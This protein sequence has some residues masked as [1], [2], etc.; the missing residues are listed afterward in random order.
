MKIPEPSIHSRLRRGEYLDRRTF[1]GNLEHFLRYLGASF[2]GLLLVLLL[3]GIPSLLVLTSTYGL[4]DAVRAHAEALLAGKFYRVNIGRV[5]FSPTR[6]FILEELKVHDLTPSQRLIV[7]ANKIA[8]SVN[9]ESLLKRQLALERIYLRDTTLDVPLG[10]TEEPR[11]RL[12]HVQGLII[13]PPSQFRVS[14]ATFEIAG[15]KVNVS[16]NFLNPRKFSPK[17]VSPEGPGKTA[18][19]IDAIQRELRSI[20]WSE[21]KPELTIQ[22]AG[23]LSDSESI[24][25]ESA[26]LRAGEG[27]WHG[28]SFRKIFI[29]LHYADRRLFLEQFLTDDGSGIFQAAGKADFRENNACVDFAGGFRGDVLPA[30]LLSDQKPSGWSAHEPVHLEGH[31]SADWMTGKPVLGGTAR[32]STGAFAYHGVK[33]DS[34]VAGVALQEGKLLIRDL[35]TSGEPGTIEADLMKAPSDNRLRLKA[36]LFPAKLAPLTG[37]KTREALEVMNF[38]DPLEINFEGGAPSFDPLQFHGEGTLN[39]GKAAM[40]DAWIDK[41]SSNFKVADGAITFRDILV[42]IGEGT[43]RGEFVYDYKNWEGRYPGVQS[44]LDPVKMMTWIDPR[45]A[46]SLKDYRFVRPPMVHLTGKV[47]LKSPEKNDLRIQLDAPAGLGYTLIHK[48]L[49]FGATKGVILLKGQQLMI[50]LPESHLFGGDVALKG[51]VSVA[52][53]DTRYGVSVHLEDVDFKTLTKLYFDYNESSGK[54]SGNYAFRAIGGDD[55]A[56]SGKGNLLIR[57]GNVLAMPIL[58]PLSLLLNDIVPGLG[59]QSA[60]QAT[61]DFTV[62][63]GVISTRDLLIQGTGFNMIG[64]GTIHYLEDSMDMSIRLNA[65]GLPGLAT[66]FISKIFEYESTGTAKH[67]QW[68]PKLLPKSAPKTP[69]NSPSSN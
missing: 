52:P 42:K 19:T 56:M 37:G 23:D 8:I 17:P 54:L 31:F 6:G 47:G 68:R 3:L 21:E 48:D 65:Q 40:R 55:R 46:Q 7:S 16:G 12:D 20:E 57:D 13:C 11:L 39:L 9:M 49:S 44:S 33:F 34:L 41:L 62:D 1:R 69:A 36:A 28:V 15:V 32:F 61:A 4:G 43:G 51:D 64:H 45:I 38:K 66:F 14:D 29:K 26:E 30:L 25:I 50:D 53:G 5:L 24:R 18:Q 35:H 2:F 63:N 58:G 10:A 59:Y 67:P 22:A 60:K 27:K